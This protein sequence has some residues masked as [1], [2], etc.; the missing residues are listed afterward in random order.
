MNVNNNPV[1]RGYLGRK[2]F[3]RKTS[4]VKPVRKYRNGFIQGISDAK[5]YYLELDD[6]SNHILSVLVAAFGIKMVQQFV[7]HLWE[8]KSI[9]TKEYIQNKANEIKDLLTT[10]GSNELKSKDEICQ[11]S[12]IINPVTKEISKLNSRYI[13]HYGESAVHPRFTTEYICTK[14]DEN[15][16]ITKSYPGKDEVKIRLVGSSEFGKKR[17]RKMRKYK[18]SRKMRKSIK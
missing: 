8:K 9:P 3:V 15:N 13:E 17:S 11:S 10:E 14:P 16:V 6:A 1:R 5:D 12:A 2:N 7:S 4:N 18:K